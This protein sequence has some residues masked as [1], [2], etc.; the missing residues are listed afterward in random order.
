MWTSLFFGLPSFVSVQ[1][2]DIDASER[3]SADSTVDGLGQK[4]PTTEEL[5]KMLESMEL[6][7]E[8]KK[9]LLESIMK[10]FPSGAGYEGGVEA[11]KASA[12]LKNM[13]MQIL[14]LL[15]LLSIITLIFGK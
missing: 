14:V 13:P 15:A 10:G 11:E 12:A 2:D 6:P 3:V 9:N 7:E 1:E 8:E 4:I 5:L